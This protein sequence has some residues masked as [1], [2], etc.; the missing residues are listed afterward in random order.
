LSTF[1]ESTEFE[2]WNI[3]K[4]RWAWPRRNTGP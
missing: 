4:K 1:K 3:S 2:M